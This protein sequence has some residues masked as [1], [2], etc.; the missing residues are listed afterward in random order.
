MKHAVRYLT[1]VTGEYC[2]ISAELVSEGRG[3][4]ILKSSILD[5]RSAINKDGL[6]QV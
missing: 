1:D 5:N 3:D 4:A 2:E 6:G